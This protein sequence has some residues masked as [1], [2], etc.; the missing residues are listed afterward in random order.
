MKQVGSPQKQS[1]NEDLREDHYRSMV[2]EFGGRY[3]KFDWPSVEVLLNLVH[4]YDVIWV[5]FAKL[6][7]ASGLSPAVFNVLMILS[8]GTGKKLKQR[9]ISKLLLSSRANVTGLVNSLVRKGLA[10]RAMD[11]N[12]RRAWLVEISSKGK[13][14]LE[15]Y[16]PFH[17]AE[18]YRILTS[19]SGSEKK[20]FSRLLCKVKSEI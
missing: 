7:A 17:Y 10:K 8:R 20:M 2:R 19:F 16:L 1:D 18:V 6:M 5:H 3:K 11:K 13:A 4:V 12:D 9:D 15:N 14:L